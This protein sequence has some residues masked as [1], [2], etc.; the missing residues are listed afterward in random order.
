MQEADVISQNDFLSENPHINKAVSLMLEKKAQD[1]V[2]FDMRDFTQLL[3]YVIIAT[4]LSTTQIDV[5]CRTLEKGLKDSGFRPLGIEGSPDSGWMLLDY[6]D[7]V[8]HV[9]GE[10]KRKYYR[11]EQLWGDMPSLKIGESVE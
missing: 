4:G 5:I 6:V 2:I 9:F 10:D 3:D 1:I 8:V 11:L 7:Y